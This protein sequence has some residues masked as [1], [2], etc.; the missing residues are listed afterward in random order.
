MQAR[1]DAPRS[2]ALVMAFVVWGA[3]L[4]AALA[5]IV[6]YIAVQNYDPTVSCDELLAKTV[7]GELG[8]RHQ[9]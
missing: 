7:E 9:K 4:L 2:E 6:I 3:G 8:R 1:F 5:A